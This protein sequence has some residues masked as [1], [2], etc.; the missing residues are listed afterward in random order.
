[1]VCYWANLRMWKSE[2]MHPQ[3]PPSSHT[4][5]AALLGQ[6]S[7]SHRCPGRG[8][9]LHSWKV[10]WRRWLALPKVM[11]L[12]RGEVGQAGFSLLKMSL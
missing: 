7:M 12:C 5:T 3:P 8:S 11:T 10:N 1:M 2:S 6:P 9:S 4:G